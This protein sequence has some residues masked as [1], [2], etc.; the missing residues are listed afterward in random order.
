MGAD[1]FMP[2]E[3][4]KSRVLE[5]RIVF[6]TGAHDFNRGEMRQVFRALR[7]GRRTHVKLLDLSHL[8][9][10]YP[11]GEDVGLALDFLDAP[12]S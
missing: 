6:I 9:H 3:P 1:Y 10:E 7:Q 5:R 4:L 12:S 8:G 2:E 11:T